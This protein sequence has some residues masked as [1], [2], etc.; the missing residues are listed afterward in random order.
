MRLDQP[1]FDRLV[2]L[3]SSM[4]DWQLPQDRAAFVRDVFQGS[5]RRDSILSQIHL[6]STARTDAVNFISFLMDFGQDE[7]GRETLGILINKL[8]SYIGYGDAASD[9]RSILAR[10]PLSTVAVSTKQIETWRGDDNPESVQEKIIGENTLRDVFMLE[11]A[12]DAARAVLHITADETGSGFMVAPDLVLT[13][14][15]VIHSREEAERSRF[16]FNYELDARRLERKANITT[17]LKGG[18]LHS[19]EELD[20]T[21]VQIQPPSEFEFTPLT[22][23]PIRV[24]RDSRV[25]IIQHPGGSYKK[26]SL[27]NNFVAYSDTRVVQYTTSTEP[28]SSGSP[29]FDDDFRV[30]AIHHAG[31]MLTEPTTM[32]RYL[33]NE[34]IS[35]MAILDDLK[36]HAS[37][38]FKQLRV[39]A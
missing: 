13:N 18:L 39:N 21:V 12:R 29:V 3:L 17:A 35:I 4:Q 36:T 6:G 27:Q 31:G 14:H 23:H 10:Y 38:I 7:P 11:L 15:H 28:G 24:K 19:N 1:D 5:P 8:L 2:S 9:L 37:D 30:V 22:L 34:G 20:Y 26:I 32:R 16:T 25:S 33:R